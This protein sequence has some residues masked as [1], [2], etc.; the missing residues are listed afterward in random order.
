MVKNTNK[1]EN[2]IF[3]M[4]EFISEAKKQKSLSDVFEL[5]NET[6]DTTKEMGV[7]GKNILVNMIPRIIQ[8][9]GIKPK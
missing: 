3:S 7:I 5:T 4:S 2:K 6:F 1:T 9:A 8:M